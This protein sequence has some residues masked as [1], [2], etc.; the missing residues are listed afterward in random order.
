MTTCHW[1]WSLK[2]ISKIKRAKFVMQNEMCFYCCQPMW[3][4]SPENFAQRYAISLRAVGR[5]QATAEHLLPRSEGG[6]DLPSNIVVACLYCNSH[7]HRARRALPPPDY[8]RMVR[9]RLKTGRWHGFTARREALSSLPSEL[10]KG[11]VRRNCGTTAEAYVQP[12]Q[13]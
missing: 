6:A 12:P 4:S 8:A 11:S 5:F 1:R 9:A 2:L 3:L 7:R 10:S 13:N